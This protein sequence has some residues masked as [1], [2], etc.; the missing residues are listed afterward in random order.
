MFRYNY[1]INKKTYKVGKYRLSFKKSKVNGGY[2]FAD[3]W[4]TAGQESFNELHP[5]YYFGA[6]VCIMVFDVT[7]KVT[8]TNLRNWYGEMRNQCPHIPCICIANKVDLQES[9]INR[10][11]KFFEEIKCPLEFV[12][13]ADGTNVVAIFQ[14]ALEAGLN[15]KQNP[16]EDDFMNDILDL[17]D[18]TKPPRRIGGNASAAAAGNEEEKKE[19]D[20]TF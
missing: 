13:A 10:R 7:R 4:D 20:F 6:H 8:Y 15:Y 14:Q 18:D 9:A 16:H 1:T 2:L 19:D 5:T 17:L 12:S 11:Y 3:I